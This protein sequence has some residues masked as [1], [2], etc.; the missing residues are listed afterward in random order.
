MKRSYG[1]N[2]SCTILSSFR[3]STCTIHTCKQDCAYR[4]AF[5]KVNLQSLD[6]T[7][8]LYTPGE[9]RGNRFLTTQLC[10][11]H[12]CMPDKRDNCSAVA[13][14]GVPQL[15]FEHALLGDRWPS[16]AG[17]NKARKMEPGRKAA[18]HYFVLN[19][20]RVEVELTIDKH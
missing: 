20:V 3:A 17:R 7:S 10:A 16:L 14:C 19:T 13:E 8:G 11:S 18:K 6:K 1:D 9:I 5:A 15:A 2:A 12:A 4:N